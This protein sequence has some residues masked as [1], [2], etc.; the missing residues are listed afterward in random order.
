LRLNRNH[1]RNRTATYVSISTEVAVY[2]NKA[3]YDDIETRGMPLGNDGKELPSPMGIFPYAIYSKR[4][5]C[6]A[7]EP[8]VLL[9]L[10]RSQLLL[11]TLP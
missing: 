11:E 1:R 10:R 7:G 4:N 2:K 5:G 6:G 3:E 9:Y 8:V